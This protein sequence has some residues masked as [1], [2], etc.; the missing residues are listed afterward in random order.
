M[1]TT[2]TPPEPPC[3]GVRA[4]GMKTKGRPPTTSLGRLDEL[5]HHIG[6]CMESIQTDEELA[7]VLGISER[8]VQRLIRLGKDQGKLG[9][10]RIRVPLAD[11]WFNRR[12]IWVTV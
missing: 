9:E 6:A 4:E 11:G 8:Q 10:K 2:T 3:S 7:K 5:L 1:E 12:T